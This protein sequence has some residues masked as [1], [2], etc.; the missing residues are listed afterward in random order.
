MGASGHPEFGQML[1]RGGSIGEAGR[2]VPHPRQSHVF[3]PKAGKGAPE[4]VL[5]EE[6]LCRVEIVKDPRRDEYVAKVYSEYDG[7]KEFRNR[8]LDTLLRE[9]TVDL[10]FSYG[11]SVRQTATENP[12]GFD[13]EGAFIEEDRF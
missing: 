4:A 13:E 8:S 5:L 3:I 2:L 6:Q 11:E 9:L 10:E 7:I 12:P 1:T